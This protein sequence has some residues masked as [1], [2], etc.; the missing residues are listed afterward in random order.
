[1]AVQKKLQPGLSN[2]RRD[3]LV[4]VRTAS[5]ALFSACGY[6]IKTVNHAT[7]TAGKIALTIKD[8]SLALRGDGEEHRVTGRISPSSSGAAA[9]FLS[10]AKLR[11]E[12]RMRRREN[13]RPRTFR[14]RHADRRSGLARS[15]GCSESEKLH[16]PELPPHALICGLERSKSFLVVSLRGL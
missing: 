5:Q 14:L 7:R 4:C 16:V 6:L 3:K 9:R 15:A 13:W 1:M 2:G 10:R 12:R 11:L 8:H